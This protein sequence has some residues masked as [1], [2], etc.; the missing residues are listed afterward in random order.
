MKRTMLTSISTALVVAS[1][2]AFGGESL[3]GLSVALMIGIIFGTYSSV[4]IASPVMLM[5]Y[6]RKKAS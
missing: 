4:F 2:I 1:L 5:F 3:R 6:K